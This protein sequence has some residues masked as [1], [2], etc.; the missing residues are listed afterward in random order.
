MIVSGNQTKTRRFQEQISPTGG[1][2]FNYQLSLYAPGSNLDFGL[3]SADGTIRSLFKLRSGFV[4]DYL[5]RFVTTYQSGQNIFEYGLKEGYIF[6]SGVTG[7]SSYSRFNSRP[8]SQG[9]FYSGYQA[10]PFDRFYIQNNNSNPINFDLNLRGFIPPVTYSSLSGIGNNIYSGNFSGNS[11]TKLGLFGLSIP[12]VNGQVNSFQQNGTGLISYTISGSNLFNGQVIPISFDTYFGRTVQNINVIGSGA[13]LNSTPETGILLDLYGESNLIFPNQSLDFE[14]SYYSNFANNVK[15]ELETSSSFAQTQLSGFGAGFLN[16]S[17]FVRKDGL[18]YSDNA[19]GVADLSS[20]ANA[21]YN[22]DYAVLDTLI[23]ISNIVPSRTTG[24]IFTGENTFTITGVPL[25]GIYDGPFPGFIGKAFSGLGD[26]VFTYDFQESDGG[27]Y[28]M[29]SNYRGFLNSGYSPNFYIYNAAYDATNPTLFPTGEAFGNVNKFITGEGIVYKKEPIN[30]FGFGNGRITPS[31]VKVAGNGTGDVL[32]RGDAYDWKASESIVASPVPP[33]DQGAYV[34]LNGITA[35]GRMTNGTINFFGTGLP[36]TSAQTWGYPTG[37]ST[38]NVGSQ[39]LTFV[40]PFIIRTGIQGY[41]GSV[42]AEQPSI[43]N[44]AGIA[45]GYANFPGFS[46]PGPV[47]PAPGDTGLYPYLGDNGSLGVEGTAYYGR[48][49]IF[50]SGGSVIAGVQQGIY[51]DI[52]IEATFQVSSGT[53]QGIFV[54]PINRAFIPMDFSLDQPSTIYP[55]TRN[56][57]SIAGGQTYITFENPLIERTTSGFFQGLGA[58]PV[59]NMNSKFNLYY[60]ENP[61][62]LGDDYRLNGWFNPTT[63]VRPVDYAYPADFKKAYLTVSYEA[64]DNAF[65]QAILKVSGGGQSEEIVIISNNT[66][67]NV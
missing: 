13:A 45:T 30:F 48:G 28:E 56:G 57:D 7:Y 27:F 40:T 59:S 66:S 20:I 60:S 53:S 24:A 35:K 26:V 42:G 44:F 39:Q 23:N 37:P 1:L 51:V 16:Y 50:H 8:L 21:G 3:K 52:S 54:E 61:D 10:K 17:G 62:V 22:L 58:V 49:C 15:I 29:N 31:T 19:T 47:F 67:G 25:N 11:S 46:Y 6:S 9:D 12:Q 41:S 14:L 55:A 43:F 38:I 5:D 32:F 63:Y 33:P 65:D 2:D 36:S 34:A 4:Y 18:I 64:D